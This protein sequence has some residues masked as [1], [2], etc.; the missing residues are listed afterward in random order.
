MDLAEIR[1]RGRQEAGKWTE[2]WTAGRHA[3]GDPAALLALHLPA[4]SRR[5]QAPEVWD[6][7][8]H[9]FFAGFEDA[10][11]ADVL[12][13]QMPGHCREVI[14]SANAICG[15]RFDLLGYESLSFGEPVDWQRDPVSG[16][17]TPVVHWSRIHPLNAAAV[18]DAKVVWELNRHQWLITLAQA[19][20]LTDDKRYAREAADLVDAWIR[21]NPY[22]HG[23]NWTSSLEVGI[24]FLSW[25]WGFLLLRETGVFSSEEL[26]TAL[27][28][29]WLHVA[30]IERYLSYYFSPNTH[31]TGEALALWCAGTLFPD[32]A[33]AARW[34]ET[35]RRILIEQSRRQIRS[36]GAHFEQA[37]CYQRYTIEIYLHLI[38][39]ADRNGD[40]LPM[41]VRDR[42][43]RMLEYLLTI[44]HPDGSMPSLGD[45]DGGWLLP[46]ARRDPTDCRGIFAL[47]A[48]LFGRSDFAWAAG[49]PAPEV[50]WLLGAD[51]ARRF[52]A[53]RPAPPSVPVSRLLPAGGQAVMRSSWRRDAHQLRLDVAPLGS[54]DSS[55]HAHAG[56]L[57][58]ECCAFGEPYL[59]DSGTFGYTAEPVWRQYFRSTVAHSTVV[60]DGLSQAEPVGAFAW[61]ARP[62]V[63]V[64]TWRSSDDTDFVDASHDGYERLPD[65]VTHRRR[66]LFVKPDYWIV[67][68]DLTGRGSH[69]VDLR[70]Q[71][72][73]RPVTIGPGLWTAASGRRGEGVWI[74]PFA[75]VPLSGRLRQGMLD[76]IEGWVSPDYG[77]RRPA[78]AVVYSATT[79]LPLRIITLVLPV[80]RLRQSPPAVELVHDAAGRLAGLTLVESGDTVDVNDV[81]VEVRRH[82]AGAWHQVAGVGDADGR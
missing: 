6:A 71:F 21:A 73:P 69:R 63:T 53:I 32:F 39:L 58:L 67:V 13:E 74:A 17:R 80:E 16:R 59:V 43:E 57:G 31:L 14:A 41:E 52:A 55:A 37:S 76:P 56:L 9:R 82:L 44:N 79:R 29:V 48:V 28:V 18:G 26:A 8:R 54:P 65:P 1:Y 2:R 4:F 42:V 15:H 33:E 64:R 61:R 20:W 3:T 40:E 77:R 49:G 68:D 72:G 24:R 35:G 75:T 22:G 38:M 11:A 25:C 30:H 62:A 51:G 5:D 27:A 23:I 10:G 36:D 12:T 81:T 46:L 50:L 45:A 60:I 78:P 7:A 47:A 70:F 34:R 66:V 19:Y